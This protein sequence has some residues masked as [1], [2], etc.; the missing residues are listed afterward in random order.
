MHH[1]NFPFF[2][3]EYS[4]N[5]FFLHVFPFFFGFLEEECLCEGILMVPV[6]RL[7]IWQLGCNFLGIVPFL[8]QMNNSTDSMFVFTTSVSNANLNRRLSSIKDA[9]YFC[10]CYNIASKSYFPVILFFP[11]LLLHVFRGNLLKSR[12][13]LFLQLWI[14][15][16][17]AFSLSENWGWGE[18]FCIYSYLWICTQ[19]LRLRG[20]SP[21][22]LWHVFKV[23]VCENVHISNFL[24]FF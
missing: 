21:T 8:L 2:P 4:H 24:S 16:S 13:L 18:P 14:V 19:L 23:C 22:F 3:L 17:D 20:V 6:V 15:G 5:N 9:V 11:L 7:I 10:G 1:T 12:F